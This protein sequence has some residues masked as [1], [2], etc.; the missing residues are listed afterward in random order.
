[1]MAYPLRP[2]SLTPA[3]SSAESDLS[4]FV[5]VCKLFIQRRRATRLCLVCWSG[6]LQATVAVLP[7]PATTGLRDLVATE[8]RLPTAP[9]ISTGLADPKHVY[10]FLCLVLWFS[11]STLRGFF[12]SGR[13]EPRAVLALCVEWSAIHSADE[14]DDLGWTI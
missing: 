6:S 8:A 3:P 7:N 10:L 5:G 9:I 1:M 2:E 14:R 4:L 13:R 12:R 11:S